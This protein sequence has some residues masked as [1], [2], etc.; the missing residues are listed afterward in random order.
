PVI[1]HNGASISPESEANQDFSNPVIYTVTAQDETIQ[2]YTVNVTVEG[3]EA[4]DITDFIIDGV[5]GVITGTNI[6]LTLPAGTDVTAL[7]PTFT[8][9]G[10]FVN[11]ASGV[12]QD[13]TNPVDYT[14]TAAD[15]TTQ[16]YTVTVS[17][18][19]A[20]SSDNDITSFV[21]DGVAG[22]ISGTTITVTLPAGTDVSALSP[23]IDH[24]GNSINPAS[25]TPQDFTT[26]VNY[27]VTAIDSSTNIYIVTVNLEAIANQAPIALADVFTVIENSSDNILDVLDNDSDPDGTVLTII[28]IETPING[29]ATIAP[30]GQSIL[31][32]ATT[33][34]DRFDYT[35]E[36]EDGAT[37]MGTIDVNVVPNQN[38][39]VDITDRILIPTTDYPRTVTFNVASSGDPDGT[40]ENYEWNFDDP[41]STGNI[42][43]N[44]NPTATSHIFDDPGTYDVVLTVTDDLGGTGFDTAQIVLEPVEEPGYTFFI[45]PIASPIATTSQEVTFIITPNATAI[46]Q[47]IIF[48]MSYEDKS[49][50]ASISTIRYN[51]SS[52][53]VNQEF[54]VNSGTTSG[55]LEG[56]FFNCIDVDYEFTVSNNLGLPNQI[57]T[58]G[59]VYENGTACLSGK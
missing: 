21:I 44:T 58:I 53:A 11:P 38:P 45:D 37:T 51:G 42:I 57:K 35:I 59:F 5:D 31:Y 34:N 55:I 39:T 18:T 47:G 43:N 19:P 6:S 3:N 29:T 40:I 20:L 9:T 49:G 27:T 54:I 13:F 52:H 46:A 30:G 26:P 22:V 17:L 10:T 41:S 48:T 50:S 33:G 23:T 56:P 4:K 28:A 24:E 36:D 25:E 32:T 2:A 14:V 7:S 15:G 12:A 16:I 8:H 1:I